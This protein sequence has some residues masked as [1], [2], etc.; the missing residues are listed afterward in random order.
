MLFNRNSDAI[1]EITDFKSINLRFSGMRI[2]EEYEIINNGDKAE[3]SYYHIVFDGDKDKRELQ[4]SAV[5]DVREVIDVLNECRAE[6]WNGFHG[7]HPKGVLDG[8]MFTF[9]ATVNGSDKIH[10]DGS[11]NFPKNFKKFEE[12]LKN[13][14]YD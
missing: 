9:E 3:I 6:K 10:A 8:R 11:E 7:K 5:C 12:W 4:K 13:K 1:K 14:L 2:I